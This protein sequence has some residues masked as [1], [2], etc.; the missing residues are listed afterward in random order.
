MLLLTIGLVLIASVAVIAFLIILAGLAVQGK[1]EEENYV[2]P[3]NAEI[4]ESNR[5]LDS[6]FNENS[7]RFY[8]HLAYNCGRTPVDPYRGRVNLDT[9]N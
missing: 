2:L 1:H 5:K 9:K 6:Q 7:D 4:E 8:E 3:T